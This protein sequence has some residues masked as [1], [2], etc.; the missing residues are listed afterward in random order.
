MRHPLALAGL[1]CM[2]LGFS[3]PG[4]SATQTGANTMTNDASGNVAARK[5][6]APARRR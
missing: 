4:C 6:P 5:T 1:E 3:V 2:A